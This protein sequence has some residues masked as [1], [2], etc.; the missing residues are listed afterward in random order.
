MP[1]LLG[2]PVAILA[3]LRWSSDSNL[4]NTKH[5]SVVFQRGTW[6]GWEQ[7]SRRLFGGIICLG[8]SCP[9]GNYL[10]VIVMGDS[11]PGTNCHWTNKKSNRLNLSKTCFIYIDHALKNQVRRI[12]NWSEIFCQINQETL[13]PSKIN[14]DN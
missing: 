7:L 14:Y 6:W 11:H 3:S 8:D 5:F 4:L 12:S 9:G 2:S 10:G 13:T 1:P